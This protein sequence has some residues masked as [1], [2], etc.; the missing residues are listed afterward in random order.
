MKYKDL[1]EYLS[2]RM[3]SSNLSPFKRQDFLS[4]FLLSQCRLQN[5][6]KK[7]TP[8]YILTSTKTTSNRGKLI[9]V[10]TLK[11][12]LLRVYNILTFKNHYRIEIEYI[13]IGQKFVLKY[14]IYVCKMYA[15]LFIC[16]LRLSQNNITKLLMRINEN[17]LSPSVTFYMI[18]YGNMITIQV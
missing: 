12:E 15:E 18:I 8:K 17:Q 6:Q 13:Y 2:Q 5:Y 10:E 4:F 7:F 1:Y 14:I 11:M 9:S 3:I 16:K